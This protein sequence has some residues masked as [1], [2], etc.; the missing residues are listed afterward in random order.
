VFSSLLQWN[1]SSDV[2]EDEASEEHQNADTSALIEAIHRSQAVIEFEPDGTIRSANDNFLDVVGY[3]LEEIQGE[4][5][6]IFVEES[7]AKSDEYQAFWEKLARGEYHADRLKRI[8][9]KGQEV[10]LQATYNPVMGPDGEVDKVVK[11][12]DDVDVP[13]FVP[14]PLAYMA[15]AAVF[16]LSSTW[17]GFGNV[18]VEALACGCPVVS[19]DC[20]SGPAEV[21]DHGRYGRLVPVGDE[22]AMAEAILA[23]LDAPPDPVLLRA[24][25]R[26]FSVDQALDRYLGLLLGASVGE[27]DLRQ[28][29]HVLDAPRAAVHALVQPGPGIGLPFRLRRLFGQWRAGA[30]GYGQH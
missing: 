25:A 19:T 10:W 12:A 8:D 15:R 17:E 22:A 24:R 16:V 18:L 6:R 28:D 29:R 11:I 26:M 30:R 7:Y 20:P 4:H 5:H 21:L 3:E 1:S 2:D 23:T 13:G 27:L 9:K 14:N